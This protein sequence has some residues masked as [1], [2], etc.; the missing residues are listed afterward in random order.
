[1]PL[2]DLCRWELCTTGGDVP[3]GGMCHWGITYG[4]SVPL[5]NSA[6]GGYMPLGGGGFLPDSTSS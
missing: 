2:G 6:I 4:E 5:G 1:V 3:L